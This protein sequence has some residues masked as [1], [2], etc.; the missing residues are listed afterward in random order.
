MKN[1]LGSKKNLLSEKEKKLSGK[2]KLCRNLNIKKRL[3]TFAA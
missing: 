2:L 1:K 3:I